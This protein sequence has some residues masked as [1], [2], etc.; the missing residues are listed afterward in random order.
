MSRARKQRVPLP[1]RGKPATAQRPARLPAWSWLL[2]LLLVTTLWL[3]S[4]SCARGPHER[5]GSA[6]AA[7]TPEQASERALAMHRSGDVLAA[8]PYYQRA[9]EGAPGQDWSTHFSYA[10]ALHSSLTGHR[11]THGWQFA[12][13]A[14]SDQAAR[15]AHAALAEYQ[16]AASL[17]AAPRDRATV[18]LRAGDLYRV[19][20]LPW[21]A[22]ASYREALALAPDDELIAARGDA[23]MLLLEHPE[24]GGAGGES[25]D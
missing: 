20:G 16:R 10:A 23:L 22:F 2:L 9:L 18:L 13:V 19:W 15:F 8:L 11:T 21:E 14:S 17:A 3:S 25:S 6:A 12:L 24:H 4:R 1:T 7:L 5:N